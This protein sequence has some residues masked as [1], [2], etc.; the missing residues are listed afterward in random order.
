MEIFTHTLQ[1]MY[2]SPGPLSFDERDHWSE[3][4]VND[5]DLTTYNG[6]EHS[7]QFY[8]M[9]LDMMEHY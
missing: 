4:T 1:D 7:A 3:P 5:P 8:D 9:I 2:W 6:D